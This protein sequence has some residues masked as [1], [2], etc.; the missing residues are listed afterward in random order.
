M[1]VICEVVWLTPHEAG[2]SLEAMAPIVGGKDG[3]KPDND[4]GGGKDASR[5]DE[6]LAQVRKLLA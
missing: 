6:A 4:H 5:L 2:R 3:G 1:R